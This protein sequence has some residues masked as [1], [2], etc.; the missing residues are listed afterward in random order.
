MP[1]SI[2]GWLSDHFPDNLT[3]GPVG[4]GFHVLF[5]DGAVWF[6]RADVPLAEVKKFFT[7][8]GSKQYDREVVLKP[9]AE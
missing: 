3:K 9:Y 6:L 8:E 5:A 2:T 4:D 7:I 1:Q